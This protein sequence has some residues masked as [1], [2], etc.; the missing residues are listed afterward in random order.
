CS[1]RI[2]FRQLRSFLR[3]SRA[4]RWWSFRGKRLGKPPPDRLRRS[5]QRKRRILFHLPPQVQRLWFWQLVLDILS[6]VP[7]EARQEQLATT[8][9]VL[10]PALLWTHQRQWL[11]LARRNTARLR[12]I[13]ILQMG[14][15]RTR[16]Y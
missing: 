16:I 4:S 12:R 2:G 6:A 9:L 13:W 8:V 14:I 10:E 1:R 5:Q 15:L 11:Q 7:A 3:L